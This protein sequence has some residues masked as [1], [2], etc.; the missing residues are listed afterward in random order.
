MPYEQKPNSGS[1]FKN[2]KRRSDRDPEYTGQ[3]EI[4]GAAYRIAAWV[5]TVKA[6]GEK[7]FSLKF[8]PKEDRGP[9]PASNSA[10]PQQE[11]DVPF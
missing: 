5:N 3:A 9:A 2:K 11:D 6:S 10:A 4:A 7:Y 1:L 8:N